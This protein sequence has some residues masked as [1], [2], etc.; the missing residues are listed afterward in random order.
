MDSLSLGEG[1]AGTQ[2]GGTGW[3]RAHGGMML[4]GLPSLL[5]SIIQDYLPRGGTAPYHV[6]HE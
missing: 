6:N 2:G 4:S 3:S 1:G 5:S